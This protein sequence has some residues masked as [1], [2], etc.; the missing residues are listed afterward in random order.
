MKLLKQIIAIS[1]LFMTAILVTTQSL[2]PKVVAETDGKELYKQ[3][4]KV[5]HEKD[6]PNGEYTPMSL[7]QDQWKSF[8]KNKFEAKHKDVVLEK[9]KKKLLEFL[10]KQQVEK[11]QKFCV[12]H[13]ADSEQPQTCSE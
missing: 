5:C 8:F 6:S 12:D 4:C 1:W 13:A 3:N 7:T 9:E 10:T 2:T 11:I